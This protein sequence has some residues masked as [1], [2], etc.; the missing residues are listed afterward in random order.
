MKAIIL[1]IMTLVVSVNLFAQQKGEAF[2]DT[3][4]SWQNEY[5]R[6]DSYV[7]KHM[8]FFTPGI[9]IDL[10]YTY[11]FNNLNDNTGVGSTALAR[12]YKV[13]LSA[14]NFISAEI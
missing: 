14:Q 5:D 9:L 6:R 1:F 12:N 3:D 8:K 13:Q 4:A 11:S 7:F 2:D 10:N